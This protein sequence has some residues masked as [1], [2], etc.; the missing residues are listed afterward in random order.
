MWFALVGSTGA[1]LVFEDPIDAWLNPRV[2]STA[3]RGPS[4]GAQSI[5]ERA[6]SEYPLGLVEKIRFPAADGQVY[7]LTLRVRP[8]R[9]GAE[10]VEATFDPVT[11]AYLGARH[12]KHSGSRR[13]I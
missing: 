6:E 4:L 11:G 5:V 1:I 13:P 9:V 12:S 3:A 2:L 7:R 10:R 8:R